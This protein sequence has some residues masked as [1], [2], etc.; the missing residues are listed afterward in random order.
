MEKNFL[1]ENTSGDK[2]KYSWDPEWE[3]IHQKEELGKYP[4]E[5]LIRV[6]ASNF[7]KVPDRKKIKILEIGC[8]KGAQIWYLANEGFDVYGIDGSSTAIMSAK[9]KLKKA[10][11]SATLIVGDVIKLGYP[12]SYFDCVV[13][14]ECLMGNDWDSARCIIEEVQRVLKIEG[15]FYSQTFTDNT[16]VGKNHEIVEKNTYRNISDGGLARKRLLRVLSE[17]NISDLYHG[18]SRL[19]YDKVAIT[20]QNRSYLSEEWLITCF[21]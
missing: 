13:D 6:I 4:S 10:H 9:D 11:L 21:K 20:Y 12:D 3:V 15:L 5:H 1:I 17:E 19:C 2:Q 18:F 7:Y 14:V 16:Y 8:G